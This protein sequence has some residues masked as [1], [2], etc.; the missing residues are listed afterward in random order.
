MHFKKVVS[1]IG[2]VLIFLIFGLSLFVFITVLVNWGSGVPSF[3]GYSFLSVTTPSMDP[4]Y[5]VGSV[6]ITKK[7]DT[8]DLAVGDVIS[9]YSEDPAIYGKPNT[10]RILEIRTNASNKTYFITKGDNN[11][12]ADYY[13]VDEDKVIG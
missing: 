12:I 1:R 3:Y 6:V 5:P 13:T 8:K 7:G 10:H 2:S 11:P 4:L 9:F